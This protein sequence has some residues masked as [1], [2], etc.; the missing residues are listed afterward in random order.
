LE[1]GVKYLFDHNQ[2]VDVDYRPFV[3]RKLYFNRNLNEMQ[4]QMPTIFPDGKSN[5][6]IIAVN[7]SNKAFNVLVA[8]HL[9]DLHFNGDA[10]CLPLYRYGNN[11]ERI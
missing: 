3:K 2:I 7:T 9:V 4:Y 6:L 10:Q 5:N 11:G 8:N 1:K